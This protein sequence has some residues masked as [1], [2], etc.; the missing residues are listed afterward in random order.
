MTVQ[1]GGQHQGLVEKTVNP[2]FIGLDTNNAVLG[3]GARA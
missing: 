3:E 2:A 1:D